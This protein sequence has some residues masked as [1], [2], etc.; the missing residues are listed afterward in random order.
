[1]LS[2]GRPYFIP[3]PWAATNLGSATNPI[4]NTAQTGGFGSWPT[5]WQTINATNPAAGGIPPQYA[6][7]QGL[8]YILSAWAQWYQAGGP[9]PYDATFSSDIGGYPQGAIIKAAAGNG[10]AWVSLVDSNTSDPDTGGANWAPCMS[11]ASS[12]R[13]NG[14]ISVEYPFAGNPNGSIAGTAAT[15]T[16]P[17]DH[18]WDY[19]NKII[20]KCTS[21]GPASGA[22]QAV[23]VPITP[24]AKGYQPYAMHGG[25]SFS[26]PAYVTQIRY[27]VIG[28]GGG[29]GGTATAA[30]TGGA[31]G[32][33]GV[34]E[35]LLTVTPSGSISVFVGQGGPGNASGVGA[36]GQTSVI[37]YG[38]TTISATGGGG[39]QG[40]G[41]PSGSQAQGGFSGAGSGGQ[42]N[43]GL[44]QG[45]S[46][47]TWALS[48]GGQS[49]GTGG[50]P[51]GQSGVFG[52]F[53]GQG[54]GGGGGGGA[55]GSGGGIG[56]G[57]D[58]SV[59]FWW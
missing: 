5:G 49:G 54:P 40:D 36:T 18:V 59:E 28:A 12:N 23:W 1:M 15:S 26:I 6:D 34:A 56:A 14:G 17:A 13:A 9:V 31:G 53:S 58:G 30:W 19:T 42:L 29:G 10:L 38:A 55:N 45:S 21:S 37:T 20:W 24:G 4:P 7:F 43:Y 22:G 2:S 27:K 46:G 35:G 41:S 3:Q 8:A 32:G 11:I 48:A 39:G 50:G 33:G 51:G 25:Y 44:G 16:T 57:A 47:A 52:G